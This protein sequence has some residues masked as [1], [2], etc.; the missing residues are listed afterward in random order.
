M[1]EGSNNQTDFEKKNPWKTLGTREVYNNPWIRV[2]EDQ[3]IRPDGKP[4]IYGVVELGQSVAVIPRDKEG[5]IYLVGQYR[6]IFKEYAWEIVTGAVNKNEDMELAAHRELQEET[7]LIAKQLT[8]L[9]VIWPSDG[10]LQEE[11]SLFLAEDLTEGEDNPDD[12]EDLQVKKVS[13]KAALAMVDRFE[14]KD[15]ASI[16]AIQKLALREFYKQDE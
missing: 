1:T 8:K 7:G 4:G 9:A 3:V 12:T 6:Y 13:L 5:N 14:I 10:V 11:Y 2:R 16:I 15:A